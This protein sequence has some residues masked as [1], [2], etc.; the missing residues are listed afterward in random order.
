MGLSRL[1]SNGLPATEGGVAAA[2]PGPIASQTI[3]IRSLAWI[4][5]LPSRRPDRAWFRFSAWKDLAL[6]VFCCGLAIASALVDL[7]KVVTASDFGGFVLTLIPLALLA[8]R[9]RLC[10]WLLIVALVC[11]AGSLAVGGSGGDFA[12]IASI[13]TIG[14]HRTWRRAAA[15]IA[16]TVLV[17]VALAEARSG[18]Q[19]LR[20]V[21]DT[22]AAAVAYSFFAAVGLYLGRRR[23]YVR[24]LVERTADL[25][26]E[27][28]VLE[29][30]RD[31]M[32]QQAVAVERAR[33]ARELHDVVAHH[34]SV[35]VIQ[36]GAAKAS[37]P[38][39][40]EATG[41]A[42]DA[43]RETGREAMAEMRR[44]L[45]LLRSDE[46]IE[47][48]ANV[49]RG[50]GAAGDATLSARAPQPGM[51]DLEALAARTSEAGV[52]V[53]LEVIGAPRHIPPGVE[54]S[55]Y[56]VAQEA[57]T[58]TLR[59]A[60]PGAKA[61]LRLRFE[62]AALSVEIVDDG[63]GRPMVESVERPRT[64]FGHGLVG[65]RERVA[66]FG[67][68]LEVGPGPGGGYRVLAWFPLDDRSMADGDGPFSSVDA[69]QSDSE[70]RG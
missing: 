51:T 54:L 8:W 22:V 49:A 34:V 3:W 64:G 43:I 63:R 65:M 4:G 45:G 27:R 32:A 50:A 9:P 6:A 37:L 33:I 13:Y 56:R 35:M 29:R 28:E 69:S 70:V 14:T 55:A 46:A 44:L 12:V 48:P 20:A 57:L 31:L 25:E 10:E 11:W 24:T 26:H 2:R 5:P 18:L 66:L 40:A 7:P 15:T 16:V 21:L 52:D 67:G 61:A 47:E 1:N 39:G 17:S 62:D 59:H 23:A 30:D 19:P 38:A 42:L 68:R 41:Q 58:N 53:T 60:G 36:A